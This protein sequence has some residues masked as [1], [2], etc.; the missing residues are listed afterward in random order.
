MT[1]A[2]RPQV[3][4]SPRKPYASAPCHRKSGSSRSW[5][6]LRRAGRPG[7]AR[8]RSTSGPP[9]AAAASQVLTADSDALRAVAMSRCLPSVVK[10]PDRRGLYDQAIIR[11]QDRRF[12][13]DTVSLR[14]VFIA[15]IYLADAAAEVV[16]LAAW[17]FVL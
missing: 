16:L 1:W 8:A 14:G 2:T 6:S 15:P 3:Q 10:R 5:A 4:S 11:P 9:W 17:A 12:R 13:L 7:E